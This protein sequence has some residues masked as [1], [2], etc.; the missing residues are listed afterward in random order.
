[1][2]KL[3]IVIIL[4]VIL[5]V[6]IFFSKDFIIRQYF[7]YKIE[8]VDYDE[9][10]LTTSYNG[11]KRYISYNSEDFR[12]VREY[13]ENEKLKDTMDIYSYE[14]GIS[15]EYN[16]K[17]NIY[18]IDKNNFTRITNI[19]NMNLLLLLKNNE[20]NM[21]FAYKGIEKVNNRDCYV[22]LFEKDKDNFNTIYLDK[23]LL[24]TI[25]EDTYNAKFTEKSNEILD[26]YLDLSLKQKELFEFNFEE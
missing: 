19:N 10:I 21:K 2:K 26:Y 24:Y 15:Y 12:I 11:K 25:R 20:E 3:I 6:I 14:K 22:L 8:N 16:V 4:I 23:E 7:I 18:A 1:M 17:N 13:D 5:S 9:Y